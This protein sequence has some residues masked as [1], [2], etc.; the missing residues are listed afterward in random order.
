MLSLKTTMQNFYH[1][2]AYTHDYILGFAYKGV[3]YAVTTS[4]AVVNEVTTIEKA[5]RGAGYSLRFKP[6][7]DVKRYLLSLGADVIC[8]K[9]FFEE[10]AT[11][12][13]YNKGEIFEQMITEKAG[14]AWVKDNIPFTDA[15][16][17]EI[18]GTAYQIKFERAT[19]INEAQMHRLE[20]R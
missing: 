17:I 8:S 6:T 14:Q 15:G 4:D 2:H 20:A 1:A 10:T 18:N 9:A 16:D 3:V 11:A 12:S 19:F 5:S 7:N 13:K